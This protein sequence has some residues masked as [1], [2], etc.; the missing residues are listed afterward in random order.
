MVSKKL[1]SNTLDTQWILSDHIG[2]SSVTADASGGETSRTL[3]QAWG[4]IRSTTGTVPTD[5]GFTGQMAEGEIYYYKARWYDLRLGRFMQADSLVP[6]M[7]GIQGFDRYAYVNN[8]PVKYTDPSGNMLWEGEPAYD[9]I[10]DKPVCPAYKMQ[11]PVFHPGVINFSLSGSHYIGGGASPSVDVYSDYVYDPI[12][13]TKGLPLVGPFVDLLVRVSQ[14]FQKMD[15]SNK[16]KVLW[17][18]RVQEKKNSITIQNFEAT[19]LVT[20]AKIARAI[21]WHGNLTSELEI[22]YGYQRLSKNDHLVNM[23]IKE[24]IQMELAKKD[25]SVRLDLYFGCESCFGPYKNRWYDLNPVSIY[26]P[27]I[28]PYQP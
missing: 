16:P 22:N 14:P 15:E 12:V 7:Q 27:Y 3:Y 2:S 4:T 19:S 11:N 10:L 24:P 23:S 8:N 18:M 26:I 5:Y 20:S 1:A 6:S 17:N 25:V 28:Y 13:M 9:P 21:L